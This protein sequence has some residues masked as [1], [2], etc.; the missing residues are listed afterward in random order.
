MSRTDTLIG[1]LVD[2]SDSMRETYE[3]FHDKAK[4]KLREHNDKNVKKT[5]TW[6]RSVLNVI[7]ELVKHD[8]TERNELF[9]FA[10]GGSS[11]GSA[12]LDL[13]K[14]LEHKKDMLHLEKQSL[15]QVIHVALDML[16]KNGAPL[17]KEWAT[18]EALAKVITKS[19]AVML[20]S[21]M[22]KSNEYM[23][24]F[25]KTCLPEECRDRTARGERVKEMLTSA[26]D[27]GDEAARNGIAIGM[28]A[29]AYFANNAI[30]GAIYPDYVAYFELLVQVLSM[31]PA[32][33][34]DY[35]SFR[36][37]NVKAF[38]NGTDILRKRAI[39]KPARD[40]IAAGD[41]LKENYP[42]F[43]VRSQSELTKSASAINKIAHSIDDT[44]PKK[45]TV[46]DLDEAMETIEPYIYGA[47][48]MHQAMTNAN[49]VFQL[50]RFKDHK[51]ALLILSDGFPTD[52]IHYDP[53]LE[54]PEV[55]V[56]SC[57]ITHDHISDSK[58][59]YSESMETWNEGSKFLFDISSQIKASNLP[60]TIFVKKGWT[61][62]FKDDKTK[63]FAQVCFSFRPKACTSK[64]KVN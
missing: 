46:Q 36:I 17:I 30:L 15:E 4:E 9:V 40:A 35:V 57:F 58:R 6:A 12:I 61:V 14:A 25:V 51:K 50:P 48:P 29:M 13:L 5:A 39:K 24:D 3:D 43:T 11:E 63:L 20:V 45:L 23:W 52:W 19:E 44:S 49:Q 18:T 22:K 1:V 31:M 37:N 53:P 33:L 42:L 41:R 10:F 8:T 34:A 56:I 28:G 2:V 47:T 7:D 64:Y 38:K 32:C 16:E 26:E 27:I 54:D 60:R 21:T 55:Y 59:L 62:D